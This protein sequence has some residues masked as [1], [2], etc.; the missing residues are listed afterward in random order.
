MAN[1][2]HGTFALEDL[3]YILQRINNLN[4]LNLTKNFI[5]S[6]DLNLIR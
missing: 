1:F 4:K 6:E 3:N 5:N 2:I